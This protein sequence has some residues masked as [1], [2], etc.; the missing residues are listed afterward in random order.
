MCCACRLEYQLLLRF[1]RATASGAES[2]RDSGT[3]A[4]R[5]SDADEKAAL[6]AE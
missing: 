6:G 2:G 3:T 4:T 1:E 5:F